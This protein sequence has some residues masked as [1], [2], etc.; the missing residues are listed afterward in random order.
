MRSQAASGQDFVG[1]KK[2]II[3]RDNI[4]RRVSFESEAPFK[5]TNW[6]N[7]V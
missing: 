4:N 7:I 2:L 6:L 1:E 3:T 5:T